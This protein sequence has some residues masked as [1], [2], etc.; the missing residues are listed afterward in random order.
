MLSVR[1]PHDRMECESS[2]G[3]PVE[4]VT[5]FVGS[6]CWP[7]LIRVQS[8]PSMFVCCIALIL[9]SVAKCLCSVQRLNLDVVLR[10][11]ERI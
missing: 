7:G 5:T 8:R 4:L 6:V 1:K 2:A 9:C 3:Y 11:S 10:T